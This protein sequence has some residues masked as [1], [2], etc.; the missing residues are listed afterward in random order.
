MVTLLKNWLV[1]CLV[2]A[3]PV[4]ALA[5]VSDRQ[6]SDELRQRRA[7]RAARLD[8]YWDGFI[9]KYEGNCEAATNK[10]QPIAELGLGYE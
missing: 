2:L 10:L 7:E 4:G 5:Q 8:P 3:G 1:I 9:L 6:L